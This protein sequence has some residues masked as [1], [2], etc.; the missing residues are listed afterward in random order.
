MYLQDMK[1]LWAMLLLWQ[2]YTD[3]NANDNN[4]DADDANNNDTNDDDNDIRRTN[5]DCIG[6]LACMPNEPKRCKRLNYPNVIKF[7]LYEREWMLSTALR[8]CVE[9][10][11][12]FQDCW[13]L[14]LKILHFF[15]IF[16]F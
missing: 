6:S 10:R 13:C 9:D 1:F 4:N 11:M 2:L 12:I 15:I 3:D 14:T 16:N 5:Q 8:T 7:L